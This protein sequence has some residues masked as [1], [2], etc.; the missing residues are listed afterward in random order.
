MK[1]IYRETGNN[2]YEIIE[3]YKGFINA[4]FWQ[5]LAVLFGSNL[6]QKYEPKGKDADMEKIVIDVERMYGYRS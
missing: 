6:K 3:D 1:L 5:T 2:C 4:A